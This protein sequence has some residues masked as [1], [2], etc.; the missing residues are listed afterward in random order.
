LIKNV[1]VA[2]AG[3]VFGNAD[4]RIHIKPVDAGQKQFGRLPDLHPSRLAFFPGQ[5]HVC[6]L[7]NGRTL[8]FGEE[9]L[10]GEGTCKFSYAARDEVDNVPPNWCIGLPSFNVVLVP[11]YFARFD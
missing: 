9:L 6:E 7:F 11:I 4:D 1:L 3:N 8:L 2:I 10:R 5:L